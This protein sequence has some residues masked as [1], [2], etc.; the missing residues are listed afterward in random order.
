MRQC[1]DSAFIKANASMDSL[2]E[3]EIPDDASAFVDEFDENNEFKVTT[4]RK[5]L[6]YQHHAWE[7]VTFK[8]MP[9]SPSIERVDE[10]GLDIYSKFL[11]N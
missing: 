3:K 1:V 6:M 4:T 2:V 10:D 8:D 9:S 5:K 11:S 7:E